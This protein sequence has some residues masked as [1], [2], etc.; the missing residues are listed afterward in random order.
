M[1]IK[2]SSRIQEITLNTEAEQTYKYELFQA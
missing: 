2:A 1:H